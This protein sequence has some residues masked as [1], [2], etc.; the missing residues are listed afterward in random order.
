MPLATRLVVVG[1]RYV[2]FSIRAKIEV[3][4][5]RNPADIEAAIERELGSRLA[6]VGTAAR[7]PGVPVTTRDLTAWIRV[8]EGMRRVTALQLV[9]EAGKESDEIKVP[10]NGLPRVDLAGS[11]FETTRAG[12]GGVP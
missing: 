10:R 5:G 3:A 9:L 11:Q 1:P 4:P 2:D 12:A 6:L 8:V 7:R